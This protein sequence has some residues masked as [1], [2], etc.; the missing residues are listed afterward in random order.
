MKKKETRKTAL[1]IITL[2]FVLA[3]SGATAGYAGETIDGCPENLYDQERGCQVQV[4][5]EYVEVQKEQVEAATINGCPANL[6][7]AEKGC[8]TAVHP[9]YSEEYTL[10]SDEAAEELINGCPESLYDSVRGCQ[11]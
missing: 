1:T 9:E 11:L 5:P 2:A 10:V 4:L 8:Q 6:F 3:I 7:D